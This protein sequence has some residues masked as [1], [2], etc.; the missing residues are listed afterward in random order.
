MAFLEGEE[1]YVGEA[2]K[3]SNDMKIQDL[4][5]SQLKQLKLESSWTHF[6]RILYHFEEFGEPIELDQVCE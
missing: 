4:Q 5:S 6:F 3:F 2:L 1:G